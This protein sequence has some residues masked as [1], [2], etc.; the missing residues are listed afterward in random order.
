MSKST[1]KYLRYSIVI[2]I[3]AFAIAGFSYTEAKNETPA[4]LPA[5]TE[6]SAPPLGS[7]PLTST[8]FVDISQKASPSVVFIQVEKS[9]VVDEQDNPFGNLFGD[10]FF[11]RFFHH[12]APDQQ[13]PGQKRAPQPR[14]APSRKFMQVGQGAGMIVSSDGY[15]IT[16]NHVAAAADR[17]TVKLDDGREFDAKVVGNDPPSD[18]AI[19]KIDAKNL[20]VLP[21]GDSDKI[22]VGEWVVA[23]GNPFGL[24]RSVSTGIVSAKGRSN[25]N[26][27]DYEDFIQTD[28]AINPGNS[29]G[30][31]LNLNGEVIG[32]NTAILS[33][34]GGSMGVGFAIPINM[35]KN[36]YNQLREHGSIVRGFLGVYLQDLTPEL[37]KSF[38]IDNKGGAL[39][40]DVNDGS[41]AQ[42]A[43]LQK[44]D[45]IVE[46][47]GKP[48]KDMNALRNQ[49]ALTP[50][51]TKADLGVIRNGKLFHLTVKIG[52]LDKNEIAQGKPAETMD[53]LGLAVQPL[54][55][56]LADQFGY[57]NKEGVLISDVEPGSPAD[58]AG[59]QAGMLIVEANRKPVYTVGE[60][61][62]IAKE[63]VSQ[64]SLLLLVNNGQFTR[65]IAI[66]F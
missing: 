36:I 46:F 27:E 7:V 31:L 42:K 41:P 20:S 26:I 6:S 37:A 24:S 51:D 22:E 12:G 39:V 35:V 60:F 49:V 59:L 66:R 16:N 62:K 13:T 32:V 55:K 43:G 5:L 21:L 53:K 61:S 30:P 57:E 29:G 8:T 18:I 11:D 10:D 48:V 50:P 45:V 44:G 54:T 40:A 2:F 34:S 63:A 1:K 25:L 19:I 9:E 14:Q 23:I 28:A 65:Y 3:A 17:I 64:G 56:D 38:D 4:P 47:Q 58:R 15:I 52:Q 33:R